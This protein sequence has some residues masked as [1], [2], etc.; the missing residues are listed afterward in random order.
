MSQ[1]DATVR[2]SRRVRLSEHRCTAEREESLSLFLDLRR[3]RDQ[4]P[5][6]VSINNVTGGVNAHDH[7]VT[8]LVLLPRTAL[9]TLSRARR[10]CRRPLF[11][12][13]RP[14]L[15]DWPLRARPTRTSRAED[16]RGRIPTVRRSET[17]LDAESR[18]GEEPSFVQARP[19]GTTTTMTATTTTTTT[20]R[21]IVRSS[22]RSLLPSRPPPTRLSL[23]LFWSFS[24]APLL[25]VRTL[26]HSFLPLTLF[27]SL[28]LSRALS[29]SLSLSRSPPLASRR[30]CERSRSL[31][32]TETTLQHRSWTTASRRCGE[33]WGGFGT[34]TTTTTTTIAVRRRR[35]RHRRRRR[36]RRWCSS[37]FPSAAPTAL[38]AGAQHPRGINPARLGARWRHNGWPDRKKS[39]I[40]ARSIAR[41]RRL[42]VFGTITL[43]LIRKFRCYRRPH[44]IGLTL[45]IE[46]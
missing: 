24:F 6:L 21:N 19:S 42:D 2:S 23:V 36:H 44:A 9:V 40:A 46:S 27:L 12:T 3:S 25:R 37:P 13:S 7:R 1:V 5:L 29:F 30:R 43:I 45:E 16:A 11:L 38:P 15:R 10:S 31:L 20:T 35:C 32:V 28:V 26:A 14:L 4:S 41:E 33:W 18:E 34:T 17:T 39:L 8:T 22:S